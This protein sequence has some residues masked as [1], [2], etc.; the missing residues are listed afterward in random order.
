MK[1]APKRPASP[2]IQSRAILPLAALAGQLFGCI[3]HFVLSM[4]IGYAVAYKR[5]SSSRSH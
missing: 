2:H 1:K 4:G 5:I 3:Q